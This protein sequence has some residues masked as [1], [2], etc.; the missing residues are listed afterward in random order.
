M[1]ELSYVRITDVI[2]WN[3][4][5]RTESSENENEAIIKIIYEQQLKKP[6]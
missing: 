5:P 2:L 3:D 4:N 6:K 1:S